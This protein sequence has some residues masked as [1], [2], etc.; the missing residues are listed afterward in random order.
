MH[1]NSD[2]SMGCQLLYYVSNC[3]IVNNTNCHAVH[4]MMN[5]LL[6]THQVSMFD[7]ARRGTSKRAKIEQPQVKLYF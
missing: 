4:R 3:E 5:I 1:T 2:L 7:Y 6:Q